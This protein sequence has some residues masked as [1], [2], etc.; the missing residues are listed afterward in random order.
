MEA[1]D[2]SL[3]KLCG[4]QAAASRRANRAQPN[5]RRVMVYMVSPNFWGPPQTKVFVELL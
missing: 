1:E 4:M 3:G 5:M 2:E